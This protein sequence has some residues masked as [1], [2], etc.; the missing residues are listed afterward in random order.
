VCAGVMAVQFTLTGEG[1]M[2]CS[3]TV[4]QDCWSTSAGVEGERMKTV[5][6]VAVPRAIVRGV[7]MRITVGMMREM[8]C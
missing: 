7:R 5:N 1:G 6:L 4:T 8:H 2:G 3:L